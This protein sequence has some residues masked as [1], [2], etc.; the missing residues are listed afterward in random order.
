M[1]DIVRKFH[2]LDIAI[3]HLLQPRSLSSMDCRSHQ[4]LLR[5]RQVLCLPQ[6]QVYKWSL[7]ANLPKLIINLI[8]IKS[9][10]GTIV[11]EEKS[12]QEFTSKMMRPDST[13]NS[14][15]MS[16]PKSSVNKV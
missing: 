6:F 12:Y 11:P 5:N 16:S 2:L 9:Q 7:D 14:S 15:F 10:T 3:V 13:F 4:K 8:K 1:G